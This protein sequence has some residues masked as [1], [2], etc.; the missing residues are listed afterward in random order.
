MAN[1]PLIIKSKEFALQIIKVWKINAR[2]TGDPSPTKGKGIA[3]GE[4]HRG[5]APPYGGGNVC[6]PY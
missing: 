5:A 3:A 1:S 4:G 2:G 6:L